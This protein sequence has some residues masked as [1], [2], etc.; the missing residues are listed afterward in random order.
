MTENAR[1]GMA[2]DDDANFAESMRLLRE[3]R[4]WSQGEMARRLTA[5]GLNGMHQTT[6]SRL[7]KGDRPVRLG[8]A[9]VIAHVL[10]ASLED[11]TAPPGIVQ[12]MADLSGRLADLRRAGLAVGS[13]VD[14]YLHAKSLLRL[15]LHEAEAAS[16][17]A[18]PQGL[19]AG[20][21]LFLLSRARE[22]LERSYVDFIREAMQADNESS[23]STRGQWDEALATL[24][25]G[26]G[27]IDTQ[28]TGGAPERP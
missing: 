16:G 17:A 9:T 11:M 10:G 3:G 21:R 25:L 4:G 23:E 5:A 19:E 24:E 6:V 15:A 13:T 28:G 8:E 2:Y 26:P 7:E 1:P 14:Q 20:R 12:T 27:G 18:A 22:E